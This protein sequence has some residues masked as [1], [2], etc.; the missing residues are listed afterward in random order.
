MESSKGRQMKKEKTRK[1]D[2]PRVFLKKGLWGHKKE[3]NI[4]RIGRNNFSVSEII[5]PL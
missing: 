4:A 3:P 5:T 2:N 1:N